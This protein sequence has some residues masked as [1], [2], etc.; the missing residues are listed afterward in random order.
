MLTQLMLRPRD[1]DVCPLM[2]VRVTHTPRFSQLC[3]MQY[4]CRILHVALMLEMTMRPHSHVFM[5]NLVLLS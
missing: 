4:H 2:C 5:R 1:D 3:N